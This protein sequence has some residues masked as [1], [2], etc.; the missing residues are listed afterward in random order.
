MMRNSNPSKA[1]LIVET[2]VIESF[3]DRVRSKKGEPSG[4]LI[5]QLPFLP[6]ERERERETVLNVTSSEKLSCSTAD[7][8][9]KKKKETF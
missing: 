8:M 2:C 3:I 1:L 6:R 7:E 4:V 9:K 5:N